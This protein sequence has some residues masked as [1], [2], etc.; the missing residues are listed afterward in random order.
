MQAS[1]H[2]S[3]CPSI[4]PPPPPRPPLAQGHLYDGYSMVDMGQPDLEAWPQFANVRGPLPAP[5]TCIDPLR[6]L[7]QRRRAAAAALMMLACAG[8]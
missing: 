4:A 2:A 1:D 8:E 5:T 7:A 6:Q 3:F